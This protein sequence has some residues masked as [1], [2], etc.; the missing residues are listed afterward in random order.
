[1]PVIIMLFAQF[2]I[3]ITFAQYSI[4]W[5][6]WIISAWP[7]NSELLNI[8]NMVVHGFVML[9]WLQF[10]SDLVFHD[11]FSI[12]L[13]S[14][15]YRLQFVFKLSLMSWCFILYLSPS[16]MDNFE[17][18]AGAKSQTQLMNKVDHLAPPSQLAVWSSSAHYANGL[19]SWSPNS[20]VD[21]LIWS[22]SSHMMQTGGSVD[23][24]ITKFPSWS[25]CSPVHLIKRLSSHYAEPESPSIE[26]WSGVVWQL[27]GCTAGRHP[28]LE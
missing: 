5:I 26:G 28:T 16:E 20:P 1:M 2:S 10:S 8:A 21:H 18:K 22:S 11:N 13:G 6:I 7:S 23:Q 25:S 15:W 24:L 9:F 14:I 3:T 27:H 4:M 12:L 19:L 17:E